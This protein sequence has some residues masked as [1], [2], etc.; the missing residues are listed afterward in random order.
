[1][2]TTTLYK[3]IQSEL[4]KQGFNR[5]IVDDKGNLIY[6][7][8]E[9]KNMTKIMKFDDDV[10][11]IV[12]SLFMNSLEVDEHDRHFK[13]SFMFR[14]LNRQINKQTVESFKFDLISTFM[15]YEDYINTIYKDSEKYIHRL[16][17]SESN[18]NA[19]SHSTDN[20]NGENSSEVTSTQKDNSLS[21]SDTLNTDRKASSNLPNSTLSFNLDDNTFSNP[22]SADAGRSKG[23]TN[24]ENTGNSESKNISKNRNTD[25]RISDTINT[26]NQSDISRSYSLD[27]LFKSTNILENIMKT[28]DGKCFLQT[29]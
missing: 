7:D 29:W 17:E 13:K 9:Y 28:F 12:D 22:S 5:E 19:T 15:T 11:K 2:T 21:K 16:S 25:E 3:I 23:N 27:D 10:K 18:S 4:F 20:S 14:F 8:S 26:G 1:M 24:T 6:F